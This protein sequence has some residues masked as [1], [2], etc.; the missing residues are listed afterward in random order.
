MNA[1]GK[2]EQI[3]VSTG[4]ERRRKI[5]RINSDAVRGCGGGGGGKTSTENDAGFP[6]LET[7]K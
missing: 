2:L 4:L 5:E 1:V 6:R 7:L 3:C